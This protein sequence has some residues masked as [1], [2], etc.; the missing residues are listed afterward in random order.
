M[1][2]GMQSPARI[3]AIGFSEL[4]AL[5]NTELERLMRQGKRPQ[6]EALAGYAFRGYNPSPLAKLVGV[7]RFLK[8]FAIDAQGALMGHNRFVRDGR[9]AIDSPWL[10]RGRAHGFYDVRP[11]EA[12]EPYDLYPEGVLLDYGSGRNAA[13]DPESVLRDILV[14]VNPGSAEL[15]LGKAFF[16]LGLGKLVAGFFMLERLCRTDELTARR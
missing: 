3:E 13:F 6:R 8:V 16:E 5:P 15:Y 9:G 1:A 2:T 12:G 7:Q 4:I 10:P 14:Q 11:I